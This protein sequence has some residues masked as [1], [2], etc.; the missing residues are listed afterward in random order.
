[1]V[2]TLNINWHSPP[3]VVASSDGPRKNRGANAEHP[4]PISQ[5]GKL[6]SGT[7]SDLM[8]LNEPWDEM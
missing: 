6:R 2:S 5:M 8:A 3:S 7:E 1:M 4:G